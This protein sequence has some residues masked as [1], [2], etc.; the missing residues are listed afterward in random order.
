[1][2]RKLAVSDISLL[3]PFPYPHNSTMPSLVFGR[4]HLLSKMGTITDPGSFAVQIEDHLRFNMEISHGQIWELIFGLA[5]ICGSY[6]PKGW[7]H[8][9]MSLKQSMRV[10]VVA[11]TRH[12]HT[13]RVT[14]DIYHPLYLPSTSKGREVREQKAQKA[15]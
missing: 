10:S 9:D 15:N 7:W 5:I 6:M 1:M 11:T 4:D 13:D 8:Q 14:G 12:C 2:R 3:T